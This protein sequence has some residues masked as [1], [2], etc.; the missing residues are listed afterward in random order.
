VRG[1]R[2]RQALD[3]PLTVS[4]GTAT[5][6]PGDPPLRP[7]DLL[8]RADQNLYAAK[9]AGKDRAVHDTPQQP[10]QLEPSVVA[11]AGSTAR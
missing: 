10:E 1:T 2:L 7:A 6:N 5:W 4:V 11:A 9:A 8:H 3:W